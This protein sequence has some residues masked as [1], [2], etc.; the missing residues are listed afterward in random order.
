MPLKPR[1]WFNSQNRGRERLLATIRRA[2][3]MARDQ[4]RGFV[5]TA[6]E[7]AEADIMN[8]NPQLSDESLSPTASR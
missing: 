2:I 1:S 4:N 6:L 7:L 3:G 5:V 8:P